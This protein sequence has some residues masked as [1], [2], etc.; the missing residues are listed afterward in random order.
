MNGVQLAE[1]TYMKP[2]VMTRMTIAILI[3]TT[4]LLKRAD[5]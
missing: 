2:N 1:F 4:A 3:K 5:S